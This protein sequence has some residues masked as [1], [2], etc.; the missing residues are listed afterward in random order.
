MCFLEKFSSF[1][2]EEMV[3]KTTFFKATTI[4]RGQEVVPPVHTEAT[5]HLLL[6]ASENKVEYILETARLSDVTEAVLSLG[7]RSQKGSPIINLLGPVEEPI[8]PKNGLL[9]QGNFQEEHLEGSLKNLPLDIFLKEIK[10]GHVHVVVITANHPEGAIRGQLELEDEPTQDNLDWDSI[11][12]TSKNPSERKSQKKPE[13]K[14][15]KVENSD[16]S[17]FDMTEFQ[18]K[19]EAGT[20]ME[21]FNLQKSVAKKQPEQTGNQHEQTGFNADEP[22][23]LSDDLDFSEFKKSLFGNEDPNSFNIDFAQ[24]SSQPQRGPPP[25]RRPPPSRYPQE[26]HPPSRYPQEGAPPGHYQDRSPPE[27]HHPKKRHHK[28]KRSHRKLLQ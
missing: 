5:G 22:V 20:T 7:I 4:L 8:N 19:L 15:K 2:K 17:D 21:D 14:S 23:K 11:L 12:S 6:K 18:K 13:K 27:H 3:S 26:R 9:S 24:N 25:G 16:S 28:K 10:R 1:P